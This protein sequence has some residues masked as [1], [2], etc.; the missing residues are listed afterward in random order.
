MTPTRHCI[1]ITFFN[2]LDS[3]ARCLSALL[4]QRTN[5]TEFLL[6]DDGSEP[7]AWNHPALR[8]LLAEPRV[9]LIRHEQNQGVSAARNSALHWCR[10]HGLDLVIMIDS[11]CTPGPD[12]IRQHLDL[13]ERFPQATVIA[14]AIVGTGNG[15]FA[16]IDGVLS[17]TNSRPQGDVR[18][19]GAN[20]V[21]HLPMT[22]IALR[23]S[24][25]PDRDF[26]YDERLHT[27]EDLLLIRELLRRGDTMVSAPSPV[28]FHQ[29]R[30]TWRSLINHHR[31]WGYH[32]YFLQFG[33]C[34][35]RPVFHPLYRAV[36][37]LA[38]GLS[39]PAY[40]LLGSVLNIAPWLRR[41]PAAALAFAPALV[42]WIAKGLAVMSSAVNPHGALRPARSSVAYVEMASRDSKRS[43]SARKDV[44][45][46]RPVAAAAAV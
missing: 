44:A 14:G 12:L 38:F 45:L 30:E 21:Y 36:F 24:R 15:V 28:V 8:R 23:L 13:Q 2:R 20:V 41:R 27:G 26:V 39:L 29:D 7:I 17:W 37:L 31:Q 34:F 11:D 5:T 6:I 46:E 18:E 43:G 25:L 9:H 35:A 22:N 16:W 1:A 10:A 4:A 33:G 19:S 40:V 3:V 42:V 32:Q